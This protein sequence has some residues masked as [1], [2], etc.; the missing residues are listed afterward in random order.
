MD[1]ETLSN[2]GWIIICILILVVLMALAGPFG[3]FIAEGVKATTVGFGQTGERALSIV[4]AN[5]GNN[6]W[7]SSKTT[8]PTIIFHSNN[9][10]VKNDVFRTFSIGNKNLETLTLNEDCTITPFYDIPEME[11]AEHNNYIFKGWYLDKDNSND[12]NPINWDMQ[13]TEDTDIYAH[14][15]H[16]G[17]VDKDIADENNTTSYHEFDIY[18]VQHRKAEFDEIPHYGEADHGLRF[19]A[20]LSENVYNQINKINTANYSGVEYGFVMAKKAT[21]EKYWD[22]TDNYTLQYKSSN[23]NGVDT[24]TTFKYVNNAKT[25]GVPDHKNYTTYRLYTVVITYKSTSSTF[26]K[27]CAEYMIV[28][29]YIKY[30]DAN[31]LERVYYNN[32]TKTEN[33]FGGY[34]ACYNDVR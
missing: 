5:S 6:E 34:Y 19:V 24:S 13:Y 1:K 12:S 14:W 32:C 25:S 8:S 29:P 7:K 3:N 27:V 26:E 22:N 16:V 4:G 23:T 9:P 28:R 31:D 10:A 18:G 11:Y 17:S 2:Y 33:I 20:V 15:I 21:A 30:T